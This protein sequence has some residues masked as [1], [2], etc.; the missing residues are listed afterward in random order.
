MGIRNLGL[1]REASTT[2]EP[3]YNNSLSWLVSLAPARNSYNTS[4]S[5][6]GSVE[7]TS[8]GGWHV[9]VLKWTTGEGLL[10]PAISAH[11]EWLVPVPIQVTC[12]IVTGMII[13]GE[14]IV[15]IWLPKTSCQSL[16]YSL[17]TPV[18]VQPTK[19]ITPSANS[20][21]MENSKYFCCDERL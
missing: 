21:V 14:A 13:F 2:R 20:S 5:I 10:K 1:T 11:A 12:V 16:S 6:R 15:D 9:T 7:T 19:V 17:E 8:V 18:I 3:P 4:V